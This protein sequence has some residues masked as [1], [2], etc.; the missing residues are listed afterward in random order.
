MQ[1]FESLEMLRNLRVTGKQVYPTL[2]LEFGK[3][4]ALGQSKKYVV[5]VTNRNTAQQQE[6]L[7]H[8]LDSYSKVVHNKTARNKS[9]IRSFDFGLFYPLDNRTDMT[10]VVDCALTFVFLSTQ[11]IDVTHTT[12][13]LNKET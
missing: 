8:R 5:Y 13:T 1:S 11:T 6:K 9:L 10:Y 3:V 7:F 2:I 4:M 12:D